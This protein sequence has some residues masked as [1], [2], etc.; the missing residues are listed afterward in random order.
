MKLERLQANMVLCSQFV[1]LRIDGKLDRAV[2][3]P[4]IDTLRSV[5]EYFKRK[6]LTVKTGSNDQES[7]SEQFSSESALIT[8]SA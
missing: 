1:E 5:G 8:T 3:K 4:K 2:I 6:Y 7:C